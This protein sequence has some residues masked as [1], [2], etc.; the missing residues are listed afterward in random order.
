MRRTFHV[1]NGNDIHIRPSKILADLASE[2]TAKTGVHLFIRKGDSGMKMMSSAN[3][4]ASL[5]IRYDEEVEILAKG[6]R[7]RAIL[8]GAL[9]LMEKAMPDSQMLENGIKDNPLRDGYLGEVD[10]LASGLFLR[11]NWHADRL[12]P[13]DTKKARDRMAVISAALS[14]LLKGPRADESAAM[15]DGMLAQDAELHDLL[16]EAER[17]IR[18]FLAVYRLPRTGDPIEVGIAVSMY[19][20]QNRLRPFSAEK[21]PNGEDALVWKIRELDELFSVNSN[22]RYVL[23][24]ADDGERSMDLSN[25]ADE[26]RFNL[27][28][29]R[30]EGSFLL[31]WYKA[32][33]TFWVRPLLKKV[34]GFLQSKKL[35]GDVPQ[36]KIKSE[37]SSGQVALEIL[38]DM[39]PQKLKSGQVQVWFV[40][41]DQND[42]IGGKKG[43]GIVLAFRKLMEILK[44]LK[45]YFIFTDMDRAVSLAESGLLLEKLASGEADAAIG[46]RWRKGAIVYG[47][48][49]EERRGSFI[50]NMLTKVLLGF[51]RIRDTQQGFKA[52]TR[53]ALDE[54]QPV[55]EDWNL[56]P[57][58][59]VDF[60]FD[61]DL[62]SRLR[63]FG[64]K[65]VEVVDVWIGSPEESTV[66]PA[67][68]VD[69]VISLFLQIPGL[70]RSADLRGGFRKVRVYD[71][72]KALVGDEAIQ[73][74]LGGMTAGNGTFIFNARVAGD[75]LTIGTSPQMYRPE[76]ALIDKIRL[77]TDI[78]TPKYGF[79]VLAGIV[80]P[81]ESGQKLS[82]TPILSGKH[83]VAQDYRKVY[84]DAVRLARF[85]VRH[86]F[87]KDLSLDPKTQ[88][89]LQS[90][91]SQG[92]E[93]KD[94]PVV[95][96]LDDLARQDIPARAEIRNSEPVRSS[97]A[98]IATGVASEVLLSREAINEEL[99]KMEPRAK[100]VELGNGKRQVFFSVMPSEGKTAEEQIASVIGHLDRLIAEQKIRKDDIFKQVISFGDITD[101]D[102]EKIKKALR[103]YYGTGVE[104]PVTTYLEQTPA[105]GSMFTVEI[106]AMGSSRHSEPRRGESEESQILR[107]AQ[108]DESRYVPEP[109]QVLRISEHSAILED[110]DLFQVYVGGIT[111]DPSITKTYDRGWNVLEKTYL[112]LKKA[113]AKLKQLDKV[114][115]DFVLDYRQVLRTWF[116][117]DHIVDYDAEGKWNYQWGIN[118]PRYDY[119]MTSMNGK[120]IPFGEGLIKGGNLGKPPASTGIGTLR[121][122]S[123]S[124][125]ME[126][127]AFVAKKSNVHALRLESARQM[128]PDEYT[129]VVQEKALE[130]KKPPLWSRA[131]SV[132]TPGYEMV[133]ISGTASTKGQAEMYI[134]D[135]VRQTLYMIDSVRMMLTQRMGDLKDIPQLRVYIK[136]PEDAAAIQEAVDKKFPDI[137][138]IYVIGDVCR[139]NWLVEVEAFAFVPVKKEHAAISP[140]VR[141]FAVWMERHISAL[142]REKDKKGALLYPRVSELFAKIQSSATLPALLAKIDGAAYAD[143][144][145]DAVRGTRKVL[146]DELASA[147]ATDPGVGAIK[148][149]RLVRQS[150]DV[151]LHHHM[152]RLKTKTAD[153]RPE[154]PV[155]FPATG[156]SKAF[157][158]GNLKPDLDRAELR[159]AEL[160]LEPDWNEPDLFK[161][162][163]GA[164]D[165]LVELMKRIRALSG[166]RGDVLSEKDGKVFFPDVGDLF[167][168]HGKGTYSSRTNRIFYALQELEYLSP[169]TKSQTLADIREDFDAIRKKQTEVEPRLRDVLNLDFR[170][171]ASV[172]Q[173][174]RETDIVPYGDLTPYLMNLAF[175]SDRA[176]PGNDYEK[177]KQAVLDIY[178]AWPKIA[179]AIEAYLDFEKFLGDFGAVFV[180]LAELTPLSRETVWGKVAKKRLDGTS[181]QTVEPVS[182][183]AWVSHNVRGPATILSESMSEYAQTRNGVDL[184]ISLI[185]WEAI[186]EILESH[187]E[188]AEALAKHGIHTPVNVPHPGAGATKETALDRVQQA[189]YFIYEVLFEAPEAEANRNAFIEKIGQAWQRFQALEAA[190]VS[191]KTDHEKKQGPLPTAQE[192]SVAYAKA[193]ESESRRESRA[194]VRTSGRLKERREYQSPEQMKLDWLED[195]I[196]EISRLLGDLKPRGNSDPLKIRES[197]QD[198]TIFFTLFLRNSRIEDLKGFLKDWGEVKKEFAPFLEDLSR[199]GTERAAILDIKRLIEKIDVYLR[200]TLQAYENVHGAVHFPD[201]TAKAV[202]A[203]EDLWNFIFRFKNSLR[204]GGSSGEESFLSVIMDHPS[205]YGEVFYKPLFELFFERI[206]GDFSGTGPF[207]DFCRDILKKEGVESLRRRLGHWD[208][209]LG[210]LL[211]GIKRGPGTAKASA[212]FYGLMLFFLSTDLEVCFSRFYALIMALQPPLEIARK[213]VSYHTRAEATGRLANKGIAFGS[214]S[215]VAK[216]KAMHDAMADKT[217]PNLPMD[218]SWI[219]KIRAARDLLVAQADKLHD[220]ELRADM[221]HFDKYA[222]VLVC[223]ATLPFFIADAGRNVARVLQSERQIN[224][225]NY[226]SAYLDSLD[227]KNPEDIKKLAVS[228][229]TGQRWV[230]QHRRMLERYRGKD[231]DYIFKATEAARQ[232]INLDFFK[233]FEK[234]SAGLMKAEVY[235]A[236]L[237]Q[238]MKKQII[239]RYKSL[240]KRVI[241]EL[242][243]T[244]R[245]LRMAAAVVGVEERSLAYW[246]AFN[247]C[248]A[249]LLRLE[250]MGLHAQTG[251]V[252]GWMARALTGIQ[253]YT[254]DT[255]MISGQQL[256]FVLALLRLRRWDDFLNEL[257]ILLSGRA[258]PVSDIKDVF[259]SDGRRRGLPRQVSKDYFRMVFS[260]KKGEPSYVETIIKKALQAQLLVPSPDYENAR[261]A[262]KKVNAMFGTLARMELR[263]GGPEG[264]V[265][266]SSRTGSIWIKSCLILGGIA[267]LYM[268]GYPFWVYME[269]HFRLPHVTLEFVRQ[270]SFLSSFFVVLFALD[271]AW[272]DRVNRRK[273]WEHQLGNKPLPKEPRMEFEKVASAKG[274]K[275]EVNDARMPE[276]RDDAVWHVFFKD[277]ASGQT[278][279]KVE[280]KPYGDIGGYRCVFFSGDSPGRLFATENPSI[281]DIVE[282]YPKP[283]LGKLRGLLGEIRPE[284]WSGMDQFL[285]AR[286]LAAK[287]PVHDPWRNVRG[288]HELRQQ[289]PGAGRPA[290]EKRSGSELR[291]VLYVPL[292]AGVAEYA[293]EKD[294]KKPWFVWRGPTQ[295][296]WQSETWWNL[297][298]KQLHV[299]ETEFARM[300]EHP[301]V[302]WIVERVRSVRA[303]DMLE[304]AAKRNKEIREKIDLLRQELSEEK[305]YQQFSTNAWWLSSF[306][307]LISEPEIVPI[308]D[309]AR[310]LVR[311]SHDKE[312]GPVVAVRRNREKIDRALAEIEKRFALAEGLLELL[313]V[314]HVKYCRFR[315]LDREM[316]HAAARGRAFDVALATRPAASD[317]LKILFFEFVYLSLD[318][319]RAAF[320]WLR[321]PGQLILSFDGKDVVFG[322]LAIMPPSVREA[323]ANR[324]ERRST[325]RGEKGL[326]KEDEAEVDL[327]KKASSPEYKK[328][329]DE[330]KGFMRVA[331]TG[332]D[333]A[334]AV[335][336]EFLKRQK[337][338]EGRRKKKYGEAGRF[339]KDARRIYAPVQVIMGHLDDPEIRRNFWFVA[340]FFLSVGDA[341]L[342]SWIVSIL[343]RDA[344]KVAAAETDRP[345][346]QAAGELLG[347][348]LVTA[349]EIALKNPLPVYKTSLRIL[350]RW[351]DRPGED[352]YMD[353]LRR[354]FKDRG[355]A[356]SDASVFFR[357]KWGRD[358]YRRKDAVKHKRNLLAMEVRELDE[359]IESVLRA[360]DRFGDPVSEVGED[361]RAERRGMSEM[362]AGQVYRELSMPE[363]AV[364][365][366]EFID[367]LRPGP[368]DRVLAVGISVEDAFVTPF[369][370]NQSHVD[371]NQPNPS[372]VQ[373]L[374][375]MNRMTVERIQR[376]FGQDLVGDR[377]HF[378]DTLRSLEKEE[379]PEN[380]YSFYVLLNVFDAVPESQKAAFIKKITDTMKDR[381]TMILSNLAVKDETAIGEITRLAARGGVE[382]SVRKSTDLRFG[383]TINR[384]N[385]L[386]LKRSAPTPI[387]SA[388]LRRGPDDHVRSEMREPFPTSAVGNGA[389]SF[390]IEKMI[391]QA[392]RTAMEEGRK[393]KEK[394]GVLTWE[395]LVNIFFDRCRDYKGAN[396]AFV[397]ETL[398]DNYGTSR[399]KTGETVDSILRLKDFAADSLRLMMG[400][401]GFMQMFGG[402]MLQGMLSGPASLGDI[403]SRFSG[404]GPGVMEAS[405]D[406]VNELQ[407]QI[408]DYFGIQRFDWRLFDEMVP[409]IFRDARAFIQKRGHVQRLL[410]PE[411]SIERFAEFSKVNPDVIDKVMGFFQISQNWPHSLQERAKRGETFNAKQL[412]SEL[413]REESLVKQGLDS[414]AKELSALW[415]RIRLLEEPGVSVYTLKDRGFWE[416][417]GGADPAERE[418]RVLEEL[419][420]QETELYR[421]KDE[422]VWRQDRVYESRDLISQLQTPAELST[423]RS[424]MRESP[425]PGEPVLA[426]KVASGLLKFLGIKFSK[427]VKAL[428]P[429]IEH[430]EVVYR[431]PFYRYVEMLTSERLPGHER[432]L[433]RLD[434]IEEMAGK[435]RSDRQFS[436]RFQAFLTDLYFA[437][438]FLNAKR[439]YGRHR[440]EFPDNR[441]KSHVKDVL[442]VIRDNRNLLQGLDGPAYQRIRTRFGQLLAAEPLEN[443]SDMEVLLK[444]FTDE[445]YFYWIMADLAVRKNW[446]R[447][448]FIDEPGSFHAPQLT[449]PYL[450][451]KDGEERGEDAAKVKAELVPND[452][453]LSNEKPF[454]AL[455]GP[456]ASG[457]STLLKGAALYAV[458]A[459]LGMYVPSPLETSWFEDIV[460][461]GPGEDAGLNNASRNTL[462]IHDEVFATEEAFLQGSKKAIEM[463]ASVITATHHHEA[464]DQLLADPS[465]S[466]KVR[467]ALAPSAQGSLRQEFDNPV[468][469]EK[470]LTS[471]DKQGELKFFY[472]KG[473]YQAG[474]ADVRDHSILEAREVLKDNGQ[475]QAIFDAA[476]DFVQNGKAGPLPEIRPQGNR[477]DPGGESDAK[478]YSLLHGHG[479]IPESYFAF[480]S[481]SPERFGSPFED[482][483]FGGIAYLSAQRYRNIK[484]KELI[485][486]VQAFR[487]KMGLP[488]MKELRR[489]LGEFMALLKK[490]DHFILL[491]KD[492]LSK[493]SRRPTPIESLADGREILKRLKDLRDISQKL[494]V[495]RFF[496]EIEIPDEEEPYFADEIK[497]NCQKALRD[498]DILNGVALAVTELGYAM[499]EK[500]DDENSVEIEAELP[501]KAGESSPRVIQLKLRGGEA[502][503][504][505][506]E[507]MDD[508]RAVL[509]LFKKT[510]PWARRGFFVPVRRIKM[511]SRF[512][513]AEVNTMLFEGLSD[514]AGVSFFQAVLDFLSGTIDAVAAGKNSV[515][516]VDDLYGSNRTLLEILKTALVLFAKQTGATLVLGARETDWAKR[517]KTS[518]GDIPL[519]FQHIG[520]DPAQTQPSAREEKRAP[521]HELKTG[522]S[523]LREVPEQPVSVR[524]EGGSPEDILAA[525]D[526]PVGILADARFQKTS[527]RRELMGGVS[528]VL[529]SIYLQL[530]HPA[531]DDLSLEKGIVEMG[532]GVRFLDAFLREDPERQKLLKTLE[533]EVDGKAAFSKLSGELCDYLKDPRGQAEL[534]SILKN[535]RDWILA[536]RDHF[537]K[538]KRELESIREVASIRSPAAEAHSLSSGSSAPSFGQAGYSRGGTEEGPVRSA[539]TPNPTGTAEKRGASAQLRRG[540]DD[541]VRSEMREMNLR[542]MATRVLE[543]CDI[544]AAAHDALLQELEKLVGKSMADDGV[545]H[546][547]KSH[548]TYI[549]GAQATLFRSLRT[550]DRETVE[551]CLRDIRFDMAKLKEKIEMIF[552]P[553]QEFGSGKEK[554]TLRAWADAVLSGDGFQT[555]PTLKL[556]AQFVKDKLDSATQEPF[557]NYQKATLEFQEK[558]EAILSEIETSISEQSVVGKSSPVRPERREG[559]VWHPPFS[560]TDRRG[561]NIW[562]MAER[563][564]EFVRVL[565]DMESRY[566]QHGPHGAAS[567]IYE[568]AHKSL[569]YYRKRHKPYIN[570]GFLQ[571]LVE[572]IRAY[573][574]NLKKN[575]PSAG[576]SEHELQ[577]RQKLV[578]MGRPYFERIRTILEEV[579]SNPELLA[580]IEADPQLEISV[581]VKRLR[582]SFKAPP[583]LTIDQRTVLKSLFRRYDLYAGKASRETK[584][585]VPVSAKPA[586]P[587]FR[588][589][590]KT[591]VRSISSA[592]TE[593]KKTPEETARSPWPI[594][595]GPGRSE[596][597]EE[598]GAR[599]VS[600]KAK[601]RSKLHISTAKAFAD[602]FVTAGLNFLKDLKLE[603]AVVAADGHV[604]ERYSWTVIEILSNADTLSYGGIMMLYLS[605]R[606][607]PKPVLEELAAYLGFLVGLFHETSMSRPHPDMQAQILEKRAALLKQLVVLGFDVSKYRI[608]Q[609][610]S[611]WVPF[612]N[613]LEQEEENAKAEKD[614][615]SEMREG[616][617][618][619][620]RN[621]L[622]QMLAAATA[623]NVLPAGA[624]EASLAS[625]LENLGSGLGPVM[626]LGSLLMQAM[627]S[628]PRKTPIVNVFSRTQPSGLAQLIRQFDEVAARNPKMELVR[629]ISSFKDAVT[630]QI[631]TE[632]RAAAA[633]VQKG[634]GLTGPMAV[635]AMLT[636]ENM[637]FPY[638]L[639]MTHP[640]QVSLWETVFR[641]IAEAD[642]SGLRMDPIAEFERAA[643][644]GWTPVQFKKHYVDN[645]VFPAWDK[646]A[647]CA[648]ESAKEMGMEPP[649]IAFLR[650]D[651]A[652]NF[653][654]WANMDPAKP[655][656]IEPSPPELYKIRAIANEPLDFKLHDI[657]QQVFEETGEDVSHWLSSE[658]IQGRVNKVLLG[659]SQ[660]TL[661]D[662]G[663]SVRPYLTAQGQISRMEREL[664]SEFARL[665]PSVRDV[666]REFSPW[667]YEIHQLRRT[668]LAQLEQM[669]WTR[670]RADMM[671]R[672]VASSLHLKVD[673]KTGLTEPKALLQP[674]KPYPESLA[675]ARTALERSGVAGDVIP[676]SD[677]VFGWKMLAERLAIESADRSVRC[678]L[679]IT[680]ERILLRWDARTVSGNLR[681]RVLNAGECAALTKEWPEAVEV[682]QRASVVHYTI[683]IPADMPVEAIRQVLPKLDS[684]EK[685]P[686]EPAR[687][688]WPILAENSK[689]GQ[690]SFAEEKKGAKPSRAEIR[691]PHVASVPQI[692]SLRQQAKARLEEI[693]QLRKKTQSTFRVELAF[694]RSS[695]DLIV[696]HAAYFAGT[697]LTGKWEKGLE[698]I[699][700]DLAGA[701]S[702]YVVEK[703][704]SHGKGNDAVIVRE[705][706]AGAVQAATPEPVRSP[707]V[708]PT[709]ENDRERA[710]KRQV[711]AAVL[712][713]VL[714][715]KPVAVETVRAFRAEI[716]SDG[717]ERVEKRL[718]DAFNNVF[719]PTAFAEMTGKSGIMAE[720]VDPSVA[721][722]I[723]M[724][725]K[726]L[727]ANLENVKDRGLAIGLDLTAGAEVQRGQ[728]LLNQFMKVIDTRG[729]IVNE[730]AISGRLSGLNPAELLAKGVRVRQIP[731]NGS[732]SPL[733]DQ[734]VV[735]FVT[736]FSGKGSMVREVFYR[737]TGES[738]GNALVRDYM[739]LLEVVAAVRLADII[740]R[741]P[742]LLRQPELLKAELLK[743]LFRSEQQG[744]EQLIEMNASG[745]GFVISG[746]AVQK[747]LEMKAR[748]SIA[749]AA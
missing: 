489:K 37:K 144:F 655:D 414:L 636:P 194:E 216:Y 558:M 308:H 232:Q 563:F 463:G 394:T 730:L 114:G 501:P 572:V 192:V 692:E 178:N 696:G 347:R 378:T 141:P 411:L 579:D 491:K 705:I 503:I 568:I 326:S 168:E 739:A 277:P 384:L 616:V 635:D 153:Q 289:G 336:R 181:Y 470:M 514:R 185:A 305:K 231:P 1:L 221:E 612:L 243:M 643:A 79:G 631:N 683:E 484:V 418:E 126:A 620:R 412:N 664:E 85:L 55:D 462:F 482:P 604:G 376:R 111:P 505:T 267:A 657:A 183:E 588:A 381:A 401:R 497:S 659:E 93:K 448:V 354:V 673:P 209:Q 207:I 131:M 182:W 526:N 357:G 47:R 385:I 186:R 449:Y 392:A 195:Q 145:A 49:D 741:Q 420:K 16:P 486:Q 733:N 46:S 370:L 592:P 14:T 191:I 408:D 466:A 7:P 296:P 390:E 157:E 134:G 379:L 236:H 560:A 396:A 48:L 667:S 363:E 525:L 731:A 652:L 575:V 584:G 660:E 66:T 63:K 640:E 727:L 17:L 196:Q 99:L 576:K 190:L 398:Q 366:A 244:E 602:G 304:L 300:K 314:Y 425:K 101:A 629:L 465:V 273:E 136:R 684:W 601:V 509:K 271:R 675:A 611:R 199:G 187:G 456:N 52:F 285:R 490:D 665:N 368:E 694:V 658:E 738:A 674:A 92:F 371:I 15:L 125:V 406:F 89:D 146:E 617:G 335:I 133:L 223:E 280:V 201:E 478:F 203:A 382:V 709:V 302:R 155:N 90:A 580:K 375:L 287:T 422:L 65:V 719:V 8:K 275:L 447:P 426:K 416:W 358:F 721:K 293:H 443:D 260:S 129:I 547:F 257:A 210:K 680:P 197:L 206:A 41:K 106:V 40:N 94:L 227:E 723:S 341:G 140:A 397:F 527:L 217:N 632:Y 654:D 461:R 735:P 748:E 586:R 124:I 569:E 202:H 487:G 703:R 618:I 269:G 154:T 386:D 28:P 346:K 255:Q 274:M 713:T 318:D 538:L 537:V 100:A 212:D 511:G 556:M 736:N 21:N 333:E 310:E 247:K 610:L 118:N 578:E 71:Q 746:V 427:W 42:G 171:R 539:S 716:L 213:D 517:L 717:V 743:A 10:R 559:G 712:E 510:I 452:L 502:N 573:D 407:G 81:G 58:F 295:K 485:E 179:A 148:N 4:L 403:V 577:K 321:D 367:S 34:L 400:R 388:Q 12:G 259:G 31:K 625:G 437:R 718:W 317:D 494:G 184:R 109:N 261:D 35:E 20:E 77:H 95:P 681:S 36:P 423:V 177:F 84:A 74:T 218:P 263:Q 722:V 165:Y 734:A 353:F 76:H 286:A 695:H 493:Q 319:D 464:V 2:I 214:P 373:V 498:L 747:F 682:Q 69:A 555:S 233:E 320:G 638:R 334:V 633:A 634:S 698:G 582:S 330:I 454:L 143:D 541:H 377:I 613:I 222:V 679:D 113:E 729:A 45:Q 457:K 451:L 676:E 135:P 435:V 298:R 38:K 32:F 283:F 70:W 39:F 350:S 164:W 594:L 690:T 701:E 663:S 309:L 193:A 726:V 668:P 453:R 608:E 86:G 175:N 6:E 331:Q 645:V 87:P 107:S 130:T 704:I 599:E 597:R 256:V 205:L 651:A 251:E 518:Y 29:E 115:P 208:P 149:V 623:A 364:R 639:A 440:E 322:L 469:A 234:N 678:R 627:G 340:R 67:S 57:D 248:R 249:L 137:P 51:W 605:S 405:F 245:D 630:Q 224:A 105:D 442:K 391:D 399:R 481:Y 104:P 325:G 356:I 542:M 728:V 512:D 521:A 62:L 307:W 488:A 436:E 3:Q 598:D 720:T 72:D 467:A 68:K 531:P 53:E 607:I 551:M 732:Y 312:R 565:E 557:R 581:V 534:A 445:L 19:G 529:S 387:A 409:H 383:M 348:M 276:T 290:M 316:S 459:R 44:A 458:M 235:R 270:V 299:Y 650:R 472:T 415:E 166:I 112:E 561:E 689:R 593:L 460:A 434:A 508:L 661:K 122:K 252:L 714:K 595:A 647:Q 532:M 117:Q 374:K 662:L 315:F 219:R 159:S 189:E 699:E 24:L 688:P 13:L 522:R 389:V 535:H 108:D 543:Q 653:S 313:K 339:A 585:F 215:A 496:P 554:Q 240:R 83:L 288:R 5:G 429:D 590:E 685:V 641:T 294:P 180:P 495:N 264:S 671:N 98:A 123:G 27:L 700:N 239:L 516:V 614:R 246:N 624:T 393:K 513:S 258:F 417:A 603:Y 200:Q 421:R 324:A 311:L 621:F 284:S 473:P 483:F 504:V 553:D 9:D 609:G 648:V 589:V 477:F 583:D 82:L 158:L 142:A 428:D 43:S 327:D 430:W 646:I 54:I 742:Q 110:A 78:K 520:G 571:S 173:K 147:V 637:I 691:M 167:W 402:F 506:A 596:M 128:N 362:T 301:D 644:A 642:M 380:A 686:A 499:P 50:Y 121:D 656:Q 745:R 600:V 272:E 102:R 349:L 228:L 615:R 533:K 480:H 702:N 120:S 474:D 265:S 23:L 471:V 151:A 519:N 528:N 230:I 359:G 544:F 11:M 439:R 303:R 707:V 500:S 174:Y 404:M 431:Y 670:V 706:P 170:S 548:G 361:D 444:N 96:T 64:R 479:I 241:D 552:A 279:V 724:E 365:A 515:V 80:S 281:P 169:K 253:L 250:A 226:T 291:N 211:V 566:A 649:D 297:F 139:P 433:E 360:R 395:E 693:V 22:V 546:F 475:F 33:L 306:S 268:F 163:S 419:R 715:Q 328:Y 740:S 345:R 710:E 127:L 103:E 446:Q 323:V 97:G 26:L 172:L 749:R 536:L 441:Y 61:T 18:S 744:I 549:R 369:A 567:V 138:I 626:N 266:A 619:P 550:G 198:V 438:P 278:R 237:A 75:T 342:F 708:G 355:S 220:E 160:I 677:P 229:R 119:F 88:Q 540:S 570:I 150:F 666:G 725:R 450:G 628:D 161:R 332:K 737:I 413:D 711:Y 352:P 351:A 176:F 591:E 523:E 238:I 697:L 188:I 292:Q 410:G 242:E 562:M 329:F 343:V 162:A 492:D 132:V 344:D 507:N 545:V 372:H 338:A 282:V 25:P 30:K 254:P 59:T 672:M 73:K 476:R 524:S 432:V 424:E 564:E 574:R 622:Q 60:A 91:F 455:L 156:E 225:F 587:V 337:D 262:E 204:E 687:N 152:N 116:Y 606:V 468:R 56:D 530:K 669:D